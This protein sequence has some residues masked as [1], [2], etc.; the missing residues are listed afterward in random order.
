MRKRKRDASRPS[1]NGERVQAH[2]PL[3]RSRSSSW[4]LLREAGTC[5]VRT[6]APLIAACI[7]RRAA[8][9]G[10]CNEALVMHC[11]GRTSGVQYKLQYNCDPSVHDR[12]PATEHLCS[13]HLTSWGVYAVHNTHARSRGR[14]PIRGRAAR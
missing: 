10:G 5:T 7:L 2:W 8:I 14:P 6:H 9:N 1:V 11:H 12:V 13:V 3:S 4:S